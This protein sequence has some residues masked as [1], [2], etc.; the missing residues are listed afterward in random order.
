MS[1]GR[2][3]VDPV[4][5][6]D[7]RDVGPQRPRSRGRRQRL[8]QIC[9]NLR[10]WFLFNRHDLQRHHVAC[11]SARGFAHLFVHLEPMA[12]L[13]V[14]LE[15]GPEGI[16]IDGA[17]NGRH[18]PRGELRTGIAWQDKKGPGTPLPSFRRSQEFCSE[19]DL[20]GG[21]GHCCVELLVRST[22]Q[23]TWPGQVQRP[24]RSTPLTRICL[25]RVVAP[26]QSRPAA[27]WAPPGPQ[28]QHPLDQAPDL[29]DR[30]PVGAAAPF[31]P[32]GRSEAR[33]A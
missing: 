27:D 8:A 28:Q 12:L 3:P 31:F 18:A 33:N 10:F 23:F 16:T 15:R 13:A 26:E 29:R 25:V 14:W 6:S 9:R 20:R 4:S 5:A 7:R 30:H 19:T 17:F 32:A 11:V 2:N 22:E 24:V 21:F 1:G